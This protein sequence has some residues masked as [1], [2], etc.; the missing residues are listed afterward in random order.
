METSKY[1]T[2]GAFT[3]TILMGLIF[4]VIWLF[5]LSSSKSWFSKTSKVDVYHIFN[6]EYLKQPNFYKETYIV[7]IDNQ[8]VSIWSVDKGEKL[9]S[10]VV[11]DEENWQCKYEN[12]ELQMKD[13]KLLG[14]MGKFQVSR[15]TWWKEKLFN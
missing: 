9:N 13:K 8:S 7:N 15:F 14:Q 1:D 5:E 3:F 6:P 10:C 12:H 4:T 2:G 11:L